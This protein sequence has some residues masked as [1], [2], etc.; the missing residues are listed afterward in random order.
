MSNDKAPLSLSDAVTLLD[1]LTQDEAFRAAFQADPAAA[2]ARVS[3]EAAAGAAKCAMPGTLASVKALAE[4]REQLI[5]QFT[6]QAMFTLPH[7][8]IDASTRPKP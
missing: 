5:E 4:A 8:F 1:L 6:A 3:P 2:L 7:C